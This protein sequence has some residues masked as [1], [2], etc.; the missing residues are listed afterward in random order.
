VEAATAPDTLGRRHVAERLVRSGQV[1]TV[2]E[3]FARYLKDGS[4]AAVPKW[5]LPV[6]EAISLVRGAGG[7]ASWAHPAATAPFEQF[8]ELRRLGLAAL[9]A[10]YPEIRGSRNRRLR[11]YAA[12]LGM[13][14]SGGSDCHGPGPRDVGSCTIS[15]EEL[16]RLQGLD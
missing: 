12:R 16:Q 2:A 8:A 13:A 11:E 6:A 4:P 1:A 9:E 15:G 14:V 7:V 5:R 10:A 3:A